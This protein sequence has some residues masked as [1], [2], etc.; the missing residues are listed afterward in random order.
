MVISIPESLLILA[1]FVFGHATW[2]VSD[3]PKDELLVP[4]VMIEKAGQREL[5]RFEG[6][7]QL[8]AITKAKRWLAENEK[9]VDL[10]V[11]ARENQFKENGVDVDALTIEAKARGMSDPVVFAQRFQPFFKGKF[12]IIGEPIA[13]IGQKAPDPTTSKRLREQL[14][15][16]IAT[17][18]VAPKH[19]DE[20]TSR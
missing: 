15:T 17:H 10:W 12:R 1:G 4:M 6:E 16:G 2:N 3:L 19:W 13:N 9:S 7:T 11:F 8:E 20:W 14:K 18:P 5:I